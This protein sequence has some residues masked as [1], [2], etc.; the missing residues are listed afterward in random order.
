MT[1]MPARVGL[2]DLGDAGRAAVDGDDDASRRRP[3]A[4][5]I[6][7]SD[8]P[9]PSSSR[10]GTYGS[11]VDAEPAQREGHDRQAGQPVGVEVA[12]DQDP[13]A[14]VAGAPAA[15]PGR[16]SASGRSARIVQAARADPRTRRPG[17][18]RRGDAAGRE[19]RRR[20]RAEIPRSAAS[21]R[22]ASAG[23]VDGSGKV[24][25]KRGS[26]TASGCHARLHRGSTGRG[27]SRGLRTPCAGPAGLRVAVEAAVPAVV[28]ELPVDEQR[29]GVED[30]RVGSRDDPDQQGQDEVAGSP[31]RRTGAARG[32]SGPR[33]GWS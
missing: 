23:A 12:E 10:L 26:T 13:L 8:R 7:A 17:R 2:R 22:A 16:A 27:A 19:E 31:R 5:S 4:A 25:R 29:A 28:P 20:A 18:P 15:A 1:S 9:W 3:T 24:Q 33:S 21:R 6:A 30:R 14:A 32:A 11:T